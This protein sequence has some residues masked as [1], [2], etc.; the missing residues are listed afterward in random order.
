[1]NIDGSSTGTSST[2]PAV[3]LVRDTISARVA[4]EGT[5][6][7]EISL[8][9]TWYSRAVLTGDSGVASFGPGGIVLDTALS[10]SV[11]GS[12]EP[13]VSRISPGGA[14][15]VLHDPEVL[16]GGRVG[17][18]SYDESSMIEVSSALSVEHSTLVG[19][20]SE[21]SGINTNGDGLYG[22]SI[23]HGGHDIGDG[24]TL[25]SGNKVS[26][27]SVVVSASLS[28]GNVGVVSLSHG[29]GLSS[30]VHVIIVG[31][32]GETSIASLV[33]EELVIAIQELRLGERGESV[34]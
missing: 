5:R 18:V 8:R 14:P 22:N 28:L 26:S 4:L 21:T 34:T 9:C 29:L 6:V 17:T 25:R 2:A 12:D 24:G 31:P 23:H 13:H 27:L 10:G 19:L 1:M 20:E 3:E 30:S 11:S 7:A 32:G 33:L 16:A 15:R